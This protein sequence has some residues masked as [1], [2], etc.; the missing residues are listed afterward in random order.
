MQ[1]PLMLTDLTFLDREHLSTTP[2]HAI[3]E[4]LRAWITEHK[5]L[6]LKHPHGFYVMLL[7]RSHD[8]QWRLHLWPNGHREITGMPARIHL[9]DMHVTSRLLIGALTNVQYIS[10]PVAAGSV[11]G[12]PVYKV[13]YEGN[14]YARQTA[15]TL[16]R[17][18]MRE[19]VTETDRLSLRAGNTYRIE[20]YTLHE[21]VVATNVAT[22]TLVCMHEHADGMVKLMGVDGYPEALSFVRTEH[23]G[24][25]FLDY[26]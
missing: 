15:N 16:R 8:E 6:C 7:K 3:K 10:S 18:S 2:T 5:P 11:S 14:R 25:I 13:V 21:A 4:A 20:R 23:D 1:T 26:L 22:C 24:S 17:T 12:H 19:A 9:H